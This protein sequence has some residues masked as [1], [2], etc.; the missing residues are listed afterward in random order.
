MTISRLRRVLLRRNYA[1]EDRGNAI[2][3]VLMVIM[4]LTALSTTASVMAINNTQ[5]SAVDRAAGTALQ[6]SEGG[7]AQALTWMQF[8]GPNALS[9][10]PGCPAGGYNDWG[11][12]PD[13]LN[14]TAPYGHTV[15]LGNGE[16]YVVWIEKVSAFMPPASRTGLYTIHS[17]GK[18]KAASARSGVRNMAVDVTVKPFEFPI[19]VFAR[20]VDAGGS[21]GVRY[22]S[23]F[24]S[25]CI[26]GRDKITFSGNDAYYGVPA[27]AHSANYIGGK[28]NFNCSGTSN[29]AIHRAGVCNTSYPND[30]D[31]GG[32]PLTVGSPCYGNGLLNGNTWLTTS[33]E[34]S[35]QGMEDTYGFKVYPNGLSNTQL[36]T[37]RTAAQQQGFYFTNTTAVPAALGAANAW[38]T[39]PHPVLFYDLKGAAIGGEVDLNDLGGYGRPYPLAANSAQCTPYG[40]VVVVLN[41]NVKLNSNTVLTANVFAPGPSPYGQV[42][43]A[44]GTGQLIG[45]IFADRVDIRGT[46]DV[47]L[48]QCFLTNMTSLWT[49]TLSEY[50]EVDR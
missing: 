47:Y 49:M 30:T 40:A 50:R 3:M 4:V 42:T 33:K 36:D 32:G 19:G 11:D 44:N 24:S 28:Q 38:Q 26:A 14:P 46:A 39:Y 22:Q 34:T 23:L 2:I 16:R 9:C 48:D 7:I 41:G 1:S 37:L 15:T 5:N 27:A 17:E 6:V 29:D 12:G 20:Q 31:L 10:S 8:W 45:T 13:P 43:K 25:N 18:S 35:P 21:G